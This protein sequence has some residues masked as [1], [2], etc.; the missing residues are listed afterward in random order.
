MCNAVNC[1]EHMTCKRSESSCVVKFQLT[2]G[3]CKI[4]Y[5]YYAHQSSC[6]WHS[7]LVHIHKPL[8][9]VVLVSM[10]C[11]CEGALTSI[12]ASAASALA[13]NQPIN[14][15]GASSLSLCLCHSTQPVKCFLQMENSAAH[16]KR[17]QQT[18]VY[19]DVFRIW[20]EGPFGTIGGFRLGRTNEAPVEWDEINA[21]WGQTVLLLKTM[22]QVRKLA[23]GLHHQGTVL[24]DHCRA[25]LMGLC[26]GSSA[27]QCPK[28]ML[29][30][31]AITYC[32]NTSHW[33]QWSH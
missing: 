26:L 24:H 30:D 5:Q 4:A 25:L 2:L 32:L 31:S 33:T 7:I 10:P 8:P 12:L 20:H 28:S 29:D 14:L 6:L 11:T 21:A 13:E 15:R 27:W 23:I 9:A 1:K 17:L 22:A 18:N 16:L 19:H 3:T